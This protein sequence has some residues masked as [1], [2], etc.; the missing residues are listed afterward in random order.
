MISVSLTGCNYSFYKGKLPYGSLNITGI[1]NAS[2]YSDLTEKMDGFLYE[3]IPAYSGMEIDRSS[4]N[5]LSVFIESYNRNPYN[6][7]E[8]GNILDYR[9]SFSVRFSVNDSTVPVNVS[10]S[11]DADI[12][13]PAAKDSV[14][15]ES[16]RNF[17]DKLR[18]EF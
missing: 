1:E 2:Y 10:K 5:T 11:L 6:Y 14:V 16:I 3:I 17:I 4:G 13:E 18:S 9:Y 12:P 7:N 15:T 8:A